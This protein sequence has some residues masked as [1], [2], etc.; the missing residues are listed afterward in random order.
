MA[1]CAAAPASSLT[2][3]PVVADRHKNDPI[4]V[5][6]P[7]G[8]RVWLYEQAAATGR[9]VRAIIADV[10]AAYRAASEPPPAGQRD[11][12]SGHELRAG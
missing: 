2:R 5:R 9:P 8:D 11:V 12:P 6:L 3:A 4:T 1:A 7:E 10:V